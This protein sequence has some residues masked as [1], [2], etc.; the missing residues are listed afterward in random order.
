MMGT[1]IGWPA[2]RL[3]A[4]L[5]CTYLIGTVTPVSKSPYAYSP[6]IRLGRRIDYV[7]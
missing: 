2:P 3:R 5:V 6:A 1:S 7:Y 4:Y